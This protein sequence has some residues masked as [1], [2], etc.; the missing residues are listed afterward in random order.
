M[1]ISNNFLTTENKSQWRLITEVNSV[2]LYD[3]IISG[4]QRPFISA[5]S[6]R[7]LETLLAQTRLT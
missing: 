5:I 2:Y 7:K 4:K 1:K 3:D 6:D